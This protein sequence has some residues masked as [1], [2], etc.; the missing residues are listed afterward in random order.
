[1][2]IDIFTFS[3]TYPFISWINRYKNISKNVET[4]TL[5]TGMCLLL[6]LCRTSGE[7]T[8][9]PSL[10]E[11]SWQARNQIVI[12]VSFQWSF[13]L[14]Y[15]VFFS[16]LFFGH[17]YRRCFSLLQFF[18]CELKRKVSLVNSSPLLVLLLRVKIQK[19]TDNPFSPVL[20][21]FK[22]T[23]TDTIYTTL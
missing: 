14:F 21:A 10:I 4:D 15:Y 11:I 13:F 23:N 3:F 18:S 16:F 17:G 20:F 8:S 12:T 22:Q 6:H 2:H 9:I 5:S 19:H 1:M 7:I